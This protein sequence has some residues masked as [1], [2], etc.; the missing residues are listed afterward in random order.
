MAQWPPNSGTDIDE[1]LLP[2]PLSLGWE[3][4]NL[5]GDYIWRQSKSIE[6]G[7]FRPLRTIEA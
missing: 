6:Q 5:A 4:I 3:L 1:R 7:K 2:L